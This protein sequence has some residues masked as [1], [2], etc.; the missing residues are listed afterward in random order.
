MAKRTAL[1]IRHVAFEDLGSFTAPLEASGYAIDYCDVGWS[2]PQV[3]NALPD[4]LVVLG[5]PIGAYEE[6]DYPFVQAELDL[7]KRQLDV[8]RPTLGICLGAQLIARALGARVYPGPEKEIGWKRIDLSDIG[9]N[10]PLRHLEDVAVLHWHGD[11]F[12][13]PADCQL[14]AS[15]AICENQAFRRG[16]NVLGL[17]FHAEAQASR[18]EQWLIGHAYE[19]AQRRI[20]PCSLREA[21]VCHGAVLEEV[22]GLM[23]DE[24]LSGTQA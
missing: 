13:L 5:G 16:P 10:S 7:L 9:R 17:Q 22:A 21:G 8:D 11:T 1:A 15:T 23:I 14:L 2:K 12:D 3:V 19:I 20:S 4:L 18:M 24:W 6:Q